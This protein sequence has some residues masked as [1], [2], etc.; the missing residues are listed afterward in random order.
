MSHH[1]GGGGGEGSPLLKMVAAAA[2]AAG[3]A[4]LVSPTT[5]KLVLPWTVASTPQRALVAQANAPLMIQPLA[6]GG[7]QNQAPVVQ[8]ARSWWS[9]FVPISIFTCLLLAAA[10]VYF[11]LRLRFVRKQHD[12]KLHGHHDEHHGVHAPHHGHEKTKEKLRWETIVRHSQSDNEN[13]WRHAIMDADILLDELLDSLGYRGDTMGDKMKQVERS[14]FNTIDL[15]WEAHKVRNRI[16]HEG[17][18]MQLNEREVRRTIGLFEQVFKEFH[19][20]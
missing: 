10:S 16:A 15:A 7:A 2:L 11:F 5:Q 8:K 4:A 14:D 1:G 18:Q 20:I 13:D 17:S 12:E 9:V 6:Q 19:L 3:F